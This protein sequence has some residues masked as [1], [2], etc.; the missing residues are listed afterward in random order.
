LTYNDNIPRSL[1][2]HHRKV[3]NGRI[4][5]EVWIINDGFDRVK[6]LQLVRISVD[7]ENA[8]KERREDSKKDGEG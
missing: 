4:E 8:E 7:A 5:K 1:L 6:R 3:V 2:Q